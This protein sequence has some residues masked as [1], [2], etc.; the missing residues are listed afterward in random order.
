MVFDCPLRLGWMKLKVKG[1][2]ALTQLQR[3]V[4]LAVRPISLVHLY[5]AL[6]AQKEATCAYVHRKSK[7]E[8]YLEKSLLKS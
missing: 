5:E 8:V 3:C 4:A 2:P 1:K 7:V 6:L